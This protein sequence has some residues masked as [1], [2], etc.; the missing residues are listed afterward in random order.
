MFDDFDL[1]GSPS[2]PLP[3]EDKSWSKQNNFNKFPKKDLRK[4]PYLPI[5]IYV[6]KE[7]PEPV[8]SNL[9]KLIDRLINKG[10]VIRISGVDLDFYNKVKDMSVENLEVYLPFKNFNEINSKLCWNAD[11]V[12]NL[13]KSNFTSYDKVPDVVKA[14][15]GCQFRMLLGERN[16]SCTNLVI[17]YTEDGAEKTLD[18]TQTT[19]KLNTIIKAADKYKIPLINIK[20]EGSLA[21]LVKTY[22]LS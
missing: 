14:I 21:N 15:L 7:Y 1:G 3:S 11:E 8:K 18:V 4:E 5:T 20:R 2:T 19:G 16:N 6:E 17:L 13:V 22:N 9:I 12:K 10:Y